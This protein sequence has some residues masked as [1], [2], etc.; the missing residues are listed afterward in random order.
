[1]KRA[2]L[3]LITVFTVM[4]LC[5]CAVKRATPVLPCQNE[6]VD[7]ENLIRQLGCG[8]SKNMQSARTAALHDANQKLFLRFC[9]SVRTSNVRI[10][11]DTVNTTYQMFLQANDTISFSFGRTFGN[12]VKCCEKMTV[13]KN[14]TY[15]AFISVGVSAEDFG[16][17]L[18]REKF[19]I[20]SNKKI[21]DII[22][23][24]DE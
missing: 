24:K 20:Y 2:T 23:P 18:S 17:N 4:A 3:I 22:I 1:M 13:D 15:H 6:A 8:N 5:G 14:G 12:I 21:N 19:R 7:D 9:D 10:K 11:I 16:I